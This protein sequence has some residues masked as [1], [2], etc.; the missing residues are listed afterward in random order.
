MKEPFISVIIPT[1]NSEGSLANA[2]ESV[3]QQ[4]YAEWEMIVMDGLSKDN[5]TGILSAFA[6][7]N[8]KL[9]WVSEKDEGI[10]DAINK[11]IRRS[12]GKWIYV[13]G[14]DDVLYDADTLRKIAEVLTASASDLVYGNVKVIGDA[15]W[16]RDGA[17]YDGEFPLEKLVQKNICQQAVFYRRSVF[18]RLGYFNPQYPVCADWDFALRCAAKGNLQF[19]DLVICS[20]AAGGASTVVKKEPFIENKTEIIYSYFGKKIRNRDFASLAENFRMLAAE[21]RKKRRWFDYFTVQRA[22]RGH[23]S[24]NSRK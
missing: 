13:L 23:V 14:S 12:K 1:Y 18:D 22:Y 8:S 11:G 4:T 7:R 5:T 6:E 21:L 15:N 2:L 19:T 3:A 24:G 10:Y 16:A 17:L 20:F 9:T